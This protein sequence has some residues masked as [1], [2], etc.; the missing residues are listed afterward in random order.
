MQ[1]TSMN[2]KSMVFSERIQPQ[3]H[4]YYVI[5]C[6]WNPGGSDSKASAYSVGGLGSIPGLG[7]SPGE[8]NGHPF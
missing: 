5:S 3:K 7:R 2:V 8:R 4:M 1:A 6:T